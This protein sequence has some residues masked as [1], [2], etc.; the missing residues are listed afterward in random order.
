MALPFVF[1]GLSHAPVCVY[2]DGGFL[3]SDLW[4]ASALLGWSTKEWKW[5][6][7]LGQVHTITGLHQPLSLQPDLNNQ[8]HNI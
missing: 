7:L 6:V 2:R 4:N 1:G 8:K 5:L 3:Y